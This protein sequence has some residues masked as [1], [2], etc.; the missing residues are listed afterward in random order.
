[1]MNL[2]TSG[3]KQAYREQMCA[4]AHDCVHS[5]RA[6]SGI[7][8]VPPP[9]RQGRGV[10]QSSAAHTSAESKSPVHDAVDFRSSP[11]IF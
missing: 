2:H 4:R 7:E 1:M 5:S 11:T 10:Q 6:A 3:H 8:I 9:E